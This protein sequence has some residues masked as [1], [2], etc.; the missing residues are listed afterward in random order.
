MT[1]EQAVEWRY[2]DRGR[3]A[4]ALPPGHRIRE[5]ARCG[6]TPPWFSRR[7]WLGSDGAEAA[8]AAG[9][10]KCRRCLQYLAGAGSRPGS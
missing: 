3:V 8:R 7:G 9:L 10:P 1:D 4:H 6:L 5:A 2:V